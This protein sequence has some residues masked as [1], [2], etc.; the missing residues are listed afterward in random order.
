MPNLISKKLSVTVG[1]PVYNEQ[2]TIKNI[3]TDVLNQTNQHYVLDQIIILSDGSTDKT[4]SEAKL[5]NNSRIKI[6]EGTIRKGKPSRMNQ[7]FSMA[8]SDVVI[9]LDAD[10]RLH[11]HKT[12][13]ELITPILQ[14][15]TVQLTSGHGVSN[16]TRTLTQQIALAG[17]SI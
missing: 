9:V 5:I 8:H 17:H 1:I 15:N 12:I 7:L 16:P 10:I 3:I 4:I 2:R 14:N 13:D 6:V 11:T